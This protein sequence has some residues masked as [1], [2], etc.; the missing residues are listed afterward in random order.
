MDEGFGRLLLFP[1]FA[2]V[3]LLGATLAPA[4]AADVSPWDSDSH[5]AARLIAGSA[6]H[7]AGARV[8]RAGLEI[9]LHPG[10]KT[11]WRY[12]GDS[13]VPPIL[14]F[15]HSENVKSINVLWPAPTRFSD[16][17]G[18]HSIGYQGSVIFPLQVVPQDVARPVTLRAQI[19]YGACEKFCVPVKARAELALSG[20]TSTQDAPLA[21]AEARVPKPAGIGDRGVLSIRAVSREA[22][23]KRPRIIVDVAAQPGNPA[24]LF[25]EGPT[26]KWA[27]PLPEPVAGGP[28]GVQ[29][30]AF[31]LDGLPPGDTP[32]GATLKLTA[33]AGQDAVEAS[34][35]LD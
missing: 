26:A 6:R 19:D 21:G 1:V 10:W 18:G 7:D 13:G 32:A 2:A 9:R 33:V 27:L 14:D 25:A 3:G 5:S 17:A 31:E 28:P 23:E 30:F 22:G 16:G 8:L 35:R 15:S 29:R 4:S 12:P 24:T 20:A 34:F 11:Y